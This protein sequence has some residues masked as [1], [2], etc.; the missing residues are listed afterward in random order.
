M[1][2]LQGECP[3]LNSVEPH[4]GKDFHLT[5]GFAK[6]VFENTGGACGD[7]AGGSTL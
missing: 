5:Y 4:L 3:V 2:G 7:G 6:Q 1:R